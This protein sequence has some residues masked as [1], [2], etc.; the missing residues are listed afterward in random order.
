MDY[1]AKVAGATAHFVDRSVDGGAIILQA[2]VEVS[3]DDTVETLH[4]KIQEQEHDILCRAVELIARNRLTV[5][6]RK[7]KGTR[8][9]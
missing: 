9:I 6:G 4:Q 3:D 1:G 7:V 5:D 8:L 2:P